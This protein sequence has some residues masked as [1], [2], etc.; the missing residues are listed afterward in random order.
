MRTVVGSR[1]GATTALVGLLV[2]TGCSSGGSDAALAGSRDAYDALVALGAR[3]DEPIVN[4]QRGLPYQ[5]IACGD[6]EVDWVE[7]DEEYADL[8]RADCAAV[9]PGGRASMAETS[10]VVGDGWVLRTRASDDGRA[11]PTVLTL[12]GAAERFGGRLLTAAEYCE[13]LGAWS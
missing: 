5:Q 8:W 4:Q 12:Q 7:D 1:W 9:S 6:L 11:T 10:V 2:L 13:V 3:C